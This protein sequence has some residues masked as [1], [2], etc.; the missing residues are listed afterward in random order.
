MTGAG[1]IILSIYAVIVAI[2]PLRILVIEI[3]LRR[4]RVLSSRSPRFDQ[5]DPPLV[6]AIVPARDEELNIADCLESICRQTYPNLEIL[7]VDDRSTDRT[8][9]IARGFA[10]RDGRVRVLSIEQ[11]PPGW[12]G[13]THALD[14]AVPHTHGQWLLF[15]DADTVH[16]P[17]SLSVLMEYARSERGSLVSLLPELNCRTFWERAVQPLAAITLM[18]SFPL[19]VVNDDRSRLA[20]ANGQYI[21]IERSAYLAAGGH[22]AV[23]ERFV[24]DIGLAE[25]VKALG[26]PIRVALVRGLVSC[27]MYSS[28][29]QLVRGWSRILYD[30]LGQKVWRL[31]LKLLDPI[32]FC[33][34]GHLALAL[35]LV[36]M[37]TGYGGPFAGWLLIL[38]LIHHGL[39]FLLFLRVYTFS[40]PGSRS[41]PWFPL[42][43]LVVD[44][45]LVRAISMC[46]TG[47][48]TWRG[49]TY[50]GTSHAAESGT[51]STP[52][53]KR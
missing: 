21:L 8:A 16:A 6:S 13:K 11:L 44:L 15:L 5:P 37:A 4:Q 17:E 18:Q 25:H 3:V 53:E 42:A 38:A 28:F 33:Q 30:A 29:N 26:L 39:M 40:V 20:F 2:W 23:R 22:R 43:N 19:H 47:N 24:E 36:L 14:Q 46:L 27:R 1:I 7:V 41:A 52:A 32:I 31:S 9:E 34:S 50:Q 10:S 51:E 49:T 35:A 45:I 48:V 12:T